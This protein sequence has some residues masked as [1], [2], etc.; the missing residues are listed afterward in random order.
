MKNKLEKH[1][2]FTEEFP[3]LRTD[4]T[5]AI[6][7]IKESLD[8]YD[9]ILLTGSRGSGKDALL[10]EFSTLDE[11]YSCNKYDFKTDVNIQSDNLNNVIVWPNIEKF[12]LSISEDDLQVPIEPV[13]KSYEHVMK[14]LLHIDCNS[15]SFDIERLE[16]INSYKKYNNKGLKQVFNARNNTIEYL[17]TISLRLGDWLRNS[18]AVLKIG[19]N[20]DSINDQMIE[21]GLF[22]NKEEEFNFSGNFRAFHRAIN[23]KLSKPKKIKIL[24]QIVGPE[25]GPEFFNNLHEFEKH[26]LELELRLDIATPDLLNYDD[27]Y[28]SGV[29]KLIQLIEK[30]NHY[31]EKIDLDKN[32]IR[33][34][35]INLGKTPI[36]WIKNNLL[37]SQIIEICME[38]E[39]QWDDG[40]GIDDNFNKMIKY[41][42]ER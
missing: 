19:Y 41:F 1:Y 12:N 39:Y 36:D 2:L 34:W 23:S 27:V 42:G 7:L 10:E 16:I 20:T 31:I 25:F 40:G 3:Y 22:K 5:E 15:E 6:K 37:Q 8:K 24:E 33:G 32:N 28:W 38:T 18:A 26:P 14:E 35:F 17:N 9:I 21:R 29:L 13:N 30:K 11:K 4:V